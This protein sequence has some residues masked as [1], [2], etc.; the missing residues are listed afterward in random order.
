MN[1]EEK[2]K[3]KSFTELEGSNVT[4]V[5]PCF[6]PPSILLSDAIKIC[7]EACKKQREICAEFMVENLTGHLGDNQM[8]Y[9]NDI[10]INAPE[11][12]DL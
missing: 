7:K 2:L 12:S 5:L 6:I 9:I 1:V 4:T 8:G 10:L 11:P 3:E